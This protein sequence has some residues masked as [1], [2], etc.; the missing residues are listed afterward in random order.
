MP[1]YIPSNLGL[2]V[3]GF[4]KERMSDHSLQKAGKKRL[5]FR[6]I[7]HQKQERRCLDARRCECLTIVCKEPVRK[8]WNFGQYIIKSGSGGVFFARR[9]ECPTKVCK[10]RVRKG[11]NAQPYI[12]KSGDGGVR[13][14]KRFE[15]LTIVCKKRVRKGANARLY[16]I[17][18][19]SGGVLLEE[20]VNVRQ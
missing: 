1:D 14:Q 16:I 12:I 3:F 4:E 5:E 7:H 13:L 8:G 18:S 11:A 17:K 20:G 9:C 10:K 6:T 15:C 19:A 2:D